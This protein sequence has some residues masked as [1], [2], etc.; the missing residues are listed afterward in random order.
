MEKFGFK[1]EPH[2]VM[3]LKGLYALGMALGLV[4]TTYSLFKGLLSATGNIGLTL[5]GTLIPMIFL[6]ALSILVADF[7]TSRRWLSSSAWAAVLLGVVAAISFFSFTYWYE[8]IGERNDWFAP[9]ARRTVE[10]FEQFNRRI[11][12]AIGVEEASN[13]A[14]FSDASA[15]KEFNQRMTKVQ[16]RITAFAASGGQGQGIDRALQKA[17]RESLG[18]EE[19][20]RAANNERIRAH[21]EKISAA[22]I[23][24]TGTQE[25][26]ARFGKTDEEL[27]EFLKRLNR[28][29]DF[30]KRDPTTVRREGN[31]RYVSDPDLARQTLQDM[32]G[33]FQAAGVR[34]SFCGP[35]RTEEEI[36]AGREPRKR[37]FGNGA[38]GNELDR[39]V[40]VVNESRD[41]LTEYSATLLR[42]Q[43]ERDDLTSQVEA[44]N[45]EN[46]QIEERIGTLNER[47][48]DPS[49]SKVDLVRDVQDLALK[50]AQSALDRVITNCRSLADIARSIDSL[51]SGG[52]IDCSATVV[53]GALQSHAARAAELARV[54][55]LCRAPGNKENI[56]L[57]SGRITSG[58][59]AEQ[60]RKALLTSL[61][62]VE[63]EVF[64]PC[65]AAAEGARVPVAQIRTDAK[66]FITNKGS[67]DPLAA[68][69][70]RFRALVVG[71][72]TVAQYFVY[73]FVVLLE[74]MFSILKLLWNRLDPPERTIVAY[75]DKPEPWVFREINDKSDRG[76]LRAGRKLLTSK[77]DNL[78]PGLRRQIESVMDDFCDAGLA[79]PLPRDTGYLITD[80]GHREV[81]LEAGGGGGQ[82]QRP[83][84]TPEPPGE[85]ARGAVIATR[86]P[87]ANGGN[88]PLVLNSR[89][90]PNS[91]RGGDAFAEPGIEYGE[92]SESL[93][94]YKPGAQSPEWKKF[95]RPH[96]QLADYRRK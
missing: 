81:R 61:Q 65:A 57:S 32:A 22:D 38:C 21:L 79:S 74:L 45:V 68:A 46:A 83:S 85:S 73:G 26:I 52:A 66:A 44:I 93:G 62:T 42:L 75:S 29:I 41:T 11:V 69:T 13:T 2:E 86:P 49:L 23:E 27:I 59:S 78:E 58:E 63:N 77:L 89:T 84:A 64:E 17:S 4:L 70:E 9:D 71:E 33:A 1:I 19:S 39:L 76:D 67:Q 82:R 18:K 53:T 31:T 55:Q 92:A 54:S 51:N 3:S 94:E 14:A 72:G 60:I 16:E 88:P 12:A 56:R 6:I 96:E 15:V 8:T 43:G 24:I 40:G 36:A 87:A 34:T 5:A 37:K 47:I 10:S 80:E 48:S 35:L 28:A 90:I 91:A 25:R 7:V 95:W 20:Q 50:P 30:E